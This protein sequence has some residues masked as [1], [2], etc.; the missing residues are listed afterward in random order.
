MKTSKFLFFVVMWSLIG[1]S[2]VAE[3][4]WGT[5]T[6]RDVRGTRG[7][8]TYRYQYRTHTNGYFR[9]DVPANAKKLTIRTGQ[10]GRGG[11]GSLDLYVRSGRLPTTS[12]YT[13]RKVGT[14]HRKTIT[15][16]NPRAGR[17][18]IRLRGRSNFRASVQARVE[19][20]P[21][22]AGMV[23]VQGGTLP[24]TAPGGRP[25]NIASFHMGKYEVT[26]GLWRTVRAQ[27]A[28]RGYDI[29]RSGAGCADNHPVH[30]VSWYD[31]VKWCNLRS[32]IE[33]RTPVYTVS[34][35]T[36]KTGFNNNVSVT[37]SANG[38]RLPTDAEW[39]FAARGG[40]RSRGYTYS[41]SDNL[42]AV[43]WHRVNSGGAACGI[44]P[45]GRGTWPVGLKAANEIGL[46]DMSGNVEE[47]CFEPSRWG[48]LSRGGSW[49]SAL[50]DH[51]ALSTRSYSAPGV[52]GDS[53]GFRAALS[54]P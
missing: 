29:G 21:A 27:A 11:S 16:N 5:K 28:A 24:S 48:R 49:S 51:C 4:Q 43:A 2:T 12:R 54:I 36:Y 47:W 44:D 18:Y 22:P 7:S 45:A 17:Y 46:R 25:L 8:W 34:G 30:T 33:R 1:L 42:S 31:V 23:Y 3:A 39:E 26:W 40:T 9:I 35:N 14:G 50:P 41:G 52:A 6:W 37:S 53:K 19:R 15:I 13:Q 20:K 10:D 32:E 38:Y